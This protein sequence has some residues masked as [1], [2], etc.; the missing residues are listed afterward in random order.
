[1]NKIIKFYATYKK[2]ILIALGL[3]ILI[4]V[5]FL[6]FSKKPTDI[7]KDKVLKN[8]DYKY[9]LRQDSI[10]LKENVTIDAFYVRYY[11]KEK[12]WYVEMTFK[13]NTD[14]EVEL[15]NYTV[16]AYDKNNKVV[17]QI[18]TSTLG[19]LSPKEVR[20]LTIESKKDVSNITNVHIEEKKEQVKEQK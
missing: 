19:T 12:K 18:D 15:K 16:K 20:I 11:A 4:I 3:I 13:N 5:G 1:M 6:L 7:M 2:I 14:S 9:E 8:E 10:K 17:K